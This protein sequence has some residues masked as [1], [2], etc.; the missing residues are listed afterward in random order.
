MKKPAIVLETVEL[1]SFYRPHKRVRYTG[2]LVN[3]VTGECFVP[4]RRVKQSFVAECDI[5]NIIK[6]Y[7]QTGQIKHMSQKAAEGAYMDLPDDLDF[8]ESMNIV[9]AGEAAFATLPSHV[10]DRFGN[11]P[12]AF[13][14][15]MADPDNQE[16]AIKLGLATR[17]LAP[18][19]DGGGDK[20]P[21][22]TTAAS[23]SSEPPK[24]PVENTEAK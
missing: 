22:N 13:L 11:S 20:P 6:Q 5:N 9:K 17:R 8:Q 7:S 23:A 16:E 21:A 10:R 18:G 15:F 14:E 24:K 3:P 12:A 1:H 4:E 2:Q 19:T